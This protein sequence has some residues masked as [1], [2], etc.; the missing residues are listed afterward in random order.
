MKLGDVVL[1][2]MEFHQTAGGKVRPAIVLL[3]AG[4]DDALAGLEAVDDRVVVAGNRT[5]FDRALLRDQLAAGVFRDEREV[6]PA[7]AQHG[8]DRDDNARRGLPDD[9]RTDELRRAQ[10]PARIGN[11]RLHEQRLRLLVDVRR[12]EADR[13]AG[14]RLI[15]SLART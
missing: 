2:R 11:D 15:S 10:S 4:D 14:E 13:R 9:A 8:D 3:D 12:D 7:D 1:L 5:D 6:L